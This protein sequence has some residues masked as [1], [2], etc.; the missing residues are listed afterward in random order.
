[1]SN[2]DALDTTSAAVAETR[3]DKGGIRAVRRAND[4]AK[5]SLYP[6]LP[7]DRVYDIL[8]REPLFTATQRGVTSETALVRSAGN[9]LGWEATREYE[10]HARQADAVRL[11]L[12]MN[13]RFF[14]F[15]LTEATLEGSEDM[16]SA[17]V[18]G[19]IT[20]VASKLGRA[21]Q[22]GDELVLDWAPVASQRDHPVV[23]GQAEGKLVMQVRA[24][25]PLSLANDV[26]TQIALILDD[27]DRY[28]RATGQTKS[29]D[30][31]ES[32]ARTII[33]A[34]LTGF[35]S[36]VREAIAAGWLQFTPRF[37]A[38]VPAGTIERSTLESVPVTPADRLNHAHAGLAVAGEWLGLTR[39]N[40]FPQTAAVRAESKVLARNIAGAMEYDG[41]NPTYEFGN[42]PAS[43]QPNALPANRSRYERSNELR[44]GDPYGDLAT[45]QIN[46][47][48]AR[49]AAMGAYIDLSKK[50]VFGVAT[51]QPGAETSTFNAFVSTNKK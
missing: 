45:L 25:D 17:Q 28:R 47:P 13:T 21:I 2:G 46:A 38:S 16:V 26:M 44:Q 39:N 49:I 30:V 4:G 19:P 51:S 33:G 22:P 29:A 20:L 31:H 11:A 7:S 34:D 8:P 12:L 36:G 35:V 1:M 10:G 42:S 50:N 6:A 43:A 3:F 15:A 27:P 40:V 14:G 18:Q 9:G 5:R 48:R 41:T 37:V 23:P 24:Y 32:L